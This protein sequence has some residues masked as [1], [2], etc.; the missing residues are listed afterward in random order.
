[1]NTGVLTQ[2]IP[3]IRIREGDLAVAPRGDRSILRLGN[4]YKANSL[5]SH[6]RVDLLRR[7]KERFGLG[8][9]IVIQARKK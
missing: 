3:E 9:G 6:A 5:P 1:M 7:M 8:G 4:S 2:V